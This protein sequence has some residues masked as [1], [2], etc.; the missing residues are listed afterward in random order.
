MAVVHAL[1]FAVGLLDAKNAR[2]SSETRFFD[3]PMERK[4]TEP[5][6]QESDRSEQSEVNGVFPPVGGPK[7]GIF[8]AKCYGLICKNV[9]P[10]EGGKHFFSKQYEKIVHVAAN[11]TKKR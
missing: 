11:W 10:T 7:S 1:V 3:R 8:D 2:D 6:E 4:K 9:L 5:N